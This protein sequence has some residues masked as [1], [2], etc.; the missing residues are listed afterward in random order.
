MQ[1]GAET[2][3]DKCWDSTVQLTHFRSRSLSEVPQEEEFNQ[4]EFQQFLTE[5]FGEFDENN[6]ELVVCFLSRF[7]LT[8]NK[9]CSIAKTKTW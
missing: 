7:C 2:E 1:L 3:K 6:T 8:S 5:A 4:V 9:T